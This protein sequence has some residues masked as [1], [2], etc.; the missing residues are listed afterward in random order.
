MTILVGKPTLSGYPKLPVL[1]PQQV[2]VIM[3]AANFNPSMMAKFLGYSRTATTMW[4][5]DNPGNISSASLNAISTLAYRVLRAL[6][7]GYY[8][9]PYERARNKDP[10]KALLDETYDR[11]LSDYSPEELLPSKWFHLIPP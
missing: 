4:V 9:I 3:K 6:K 2:A 7:V 10:F 11:P 5:S 8:P 1:L